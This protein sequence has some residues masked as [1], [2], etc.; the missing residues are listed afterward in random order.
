M[1]FCI[2]LYFFQVRKPRLQMQPDCP[3]AHRL[4]QGWPCGGWQALQA[5]FFLPAALQ[6][7]PFQLDSSS[8][9]AS[10]HVQGCWGTTGGWATSGQGLRRQD[11]CREGSVH[12]DACARRY[13]CMDARVHF[14]YPGPMSAPGACSLL[15]CPAVDCF[16]GL[17]RR[18]CLNP[19][20]GGR[21]CFALSM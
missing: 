8:A 10:C 5:L 6:A 20:L 4:R 14:T 16:P 1:A 7:L 11:G 18:S 19:F 2:G 3:H 15:F 9:P 12:E 13:V 17:E 21:V